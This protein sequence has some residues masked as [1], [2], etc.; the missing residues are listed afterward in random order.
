MISMKVFFTFL[1][2]P[3]TSQNTI[4]KDHEENSVESTS[5]NYQQKLPANEFEDFGDVPLH[6]S[7]TFGLLS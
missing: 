6:H 7:R 5:K 4:W 2:S 1:G 3:R